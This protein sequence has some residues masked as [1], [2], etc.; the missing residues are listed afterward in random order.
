MTTRVFH[1]V[2]QRWSELALA[3]IAAASLAGCTGGQNGI[4]VASNGGGGGAGALG[5]I[6]MTSFK[7]RLGN[8]YAVVGYSSQ[9]QILNVSFGANISTTSSTVM[10]ADGTCARGVANII[11]RAKKTA[12][13]G[14]GATTHD[15]TSTLKCTADTFSWTPSAGIEV[16]FSV[17]AEGTWELKFIPVDA[18]AVEHEDLGGAVNVTIDF[19]APA[20]PTVPLIDGNGC[21]SGVWASCGTT[22]ISQGADPVIHMTVPVATHKMNMTGGNADIDSENFTDGAAEYTLHLNAG[23]SAT[24]T[25]QTYDELGNT[26]GDLQASVSYTAPLAGNGDSFV[27]TSMSVDG[28]SVSSGSYKLERAVAEEHSSAPTASTGDTGYT[29]QSGKVPYLLGL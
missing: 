17:S 29:G 7:Q 9:N 3:V 10:Q 13:V 27:V 22:Y 16:P 20:A 19:T 26:S 18:F 12:G 24:Y 15:L 5:S 14:S 28:A 8:G 6:A 23:Q 4:S 25:F 1:S 21:P 2:R 11:V